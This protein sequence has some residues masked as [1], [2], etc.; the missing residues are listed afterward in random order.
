VIGRG[1]I[2]ASP[3][4]EYHV[5][6]K[7]L[8]A[9]VRPRERLQQDGPERLNNTELLAIILRTGSRR[10]NVL[11]LSNSLL[12]RLKG[13]D[14]VGQASITE[15][16]DTVGLGPAKAI[17]LKA[18]FELGRRLAQVQPENRRQVRSPGDLAPH[19]I[20]Q[21]GHLQQEHLKVVLLNTRNRVLAEEDVCRGSLNSAAVR[22]AE[23]YREPIRQNAAAIILV[24]NHPSGDPSPSPEDV[25]LTA[26]VRQ[27]GELLDIEL[28]D[29]IVV[30]RQEFISLR[31]R[32]LGF[33]HGKSVQS[34]A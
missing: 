5:G 27:A 34:K 24:H 13:L 31:E 26:T 28:L 9:D 10:A 29:H 18:A 32:G 25:R 30:G 21:M 22:V 3:T 15:L 33:A 12:A 8:P 7:D 6:L 23:V 17:Q 14:G 2:A 4:V 16:C 11:E 1:K 20:S 19:M